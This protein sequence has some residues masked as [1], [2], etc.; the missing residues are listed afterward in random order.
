[1]IERTDRLALVVLDAVAAIDSYEQIFDCRVVDDRPDDDAGARR[2][3]LQWGQD[4][5]ELYQPTGPG[6]AAS[7][8]E[9]GGRGLFA[10]GFSLADPGALAGRL[11]SEGLRVH[12]QGEERYVIYPDDLDGTGVILSKRV[13]RD[14]VGLS[15]KIWQI[16]YAVPS[17]E[18]AVPRYS[19]LFRVEDDFTNIYPSEEF[20]Y[21]AAITWFDARDGGLLDSLEYLE[22][23][24]EDVAVSRFLHR[25]GQ[26]IYMASIETDDT[27]EIRRRITSTGPGWDDRG[28]GG[29]IHPRRLH[30]L[31]V[32][33]VRYE[34]WN[35]RRPLPT[36]EPE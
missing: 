2:V 24:R 32:A 19:R 25:N 21:D 11:E 20:G 4:Q 8:L 3:T 36:E 26:G 34:E 30:G 1:M 31:L 9:R 16:T 22:P 13:E 14:R 17:L 6:H 28:F 29:F 23:T 10:G 35:S 18:K 7:F 12:D 33:L 5:L 15:D 27:A